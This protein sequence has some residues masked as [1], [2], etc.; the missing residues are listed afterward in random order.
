MI[1]RQLTLVATVIALALSSSAWA[2][3]ACPI[4]D[5]VPAAEWQDKGSLEKKLV[6]AGWQV[7]R[8]K[9]DAQCYE[10]YGVDDKGQR[11]EAYFHP[12]TLEPAKAP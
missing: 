9:V 11:V 2:T 10:V 3:G 6:A 1:Q 12:K 5:T 7:R 4:K 8:I